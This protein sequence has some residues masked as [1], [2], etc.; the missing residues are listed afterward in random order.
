MADYIISCFAL[1]VKFR[2]ECYQRLTA[3]RAAKVDVTVML[4]NDT[5]S[6]TCVDQVHTI[7]FTLICHSLSTIL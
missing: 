7:T 3:L 6:N 2:Q 4:T 5:L 1:G